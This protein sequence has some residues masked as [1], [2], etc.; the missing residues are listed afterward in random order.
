MYTWKKDLY[1]RYPAHSSVG[2]DD[3]NGTLLTFKT[4]VTS[5]KAN[6]KFLFPIPSSEIPGRMKSNSSPSVTDALEFCR[7]FMM[8]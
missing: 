5:C 1:D 7:C 4:V 8:V 6:F 2:Y 3:A